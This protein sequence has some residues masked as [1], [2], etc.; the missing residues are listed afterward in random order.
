MT[1]SP[2]LVGIALNV[3]AVRAALPDHPS[4]IATLKDDNEVTFDPLGVAA[5]LHN[6]RASLSAARLYTQYDHSIFTW[7]HTMMMGAALIPVK[8]LVE[9]LTATFQ[10]IHPAISLCTR[11]TQTLAVVSNMVFKE[12]PLDFSKMWVGDVIAYKSSTKPVND[13][14]I[15]CMDEEL[16]QDR[17]HQGPSKATRWL[18]R[19]VLDAIMIMNG[20][21]LAVGAILGSL[22]IDIWAITLFCFYLIHCVAGF[23]IS[24]TPLVVP[25][26]MTIKDDSTVR[27][28]IYQRPAGGT[29]VFKG[30]QDTMERWARITWEFKRSFYNDCLHWFWMISGTLSAIASVACMVNMQGFIQLIFL[31]QLVYASLAE[32]VAT[33]VARILGGQANASNRTYLVSGNTFRT[34]GIIRATIEAD[35]Q[36]RLVGLDWVGLKRMPADRIFIDMQD[37]LLKQINEVQERIEAGN[38]VDSVPESDPASHPDVMAAFEAFRANRTDDEDPVLVQRIQDET[39]TALQTWWEKRRKT[40]DGGARNGRP[41]V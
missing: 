18:G 6:P 15:V 36:F 20:M 1:L 37:L 8:V 14:M 17:Q 7:P 12:F 35:A 5:V 27:Y 3:G 26:K 16:A 39:R 38:D 21:I 23:A 25:Q 13:F 2:Y 19:R 30:R 29:V 24:H 31:G 33:R 9:H 40:A 11:D 4:A 32:I 22:Y 28:A 34:N 10:S 41:P